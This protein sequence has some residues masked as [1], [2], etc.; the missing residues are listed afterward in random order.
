MQFQKNEVFA[1]SIVNSKHF[2]KT[3]QKLTKLTELQNMLLKTN[4]S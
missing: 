2:S 3:E 1:S 4:K